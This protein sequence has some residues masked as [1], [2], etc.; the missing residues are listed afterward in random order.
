MSK[1]KVILDIDGVL[2]NFLKQACKYHGKDYDSMMQEWDPGN[3][4]CNKPFG[5]T[6]DHA[7]FWKP[8]DRAFWA[9]ME[10]YEGAS[11][12]VN[13]IEE[14]VGAENICLCTSPS[15]CPQSAAGKMEWIARNFPAYK[16]R[17]LIGPAKE[18]CAS[19]NTVLI[20]DCGLNVVKFGDA[21]GSAFLF[22]ALWNSLHGMAKRSFE[23][24]LHEVASHKKFLYAK[25]LML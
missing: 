10:M 9:G 14:T 6:E 19:N 18:F 21:G 20:D 25:R 12:F 13:G 17:F 24:I 22:P 7:G 4:D 15:E 2:G 16:R 11:A 8:F 23:H 5:F 3:Y 1:L